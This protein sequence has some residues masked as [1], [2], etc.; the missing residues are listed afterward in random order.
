MLVNVTNQRLI[1]MDI[2]YSIGEKVDSFAYDFVNRKCVSIDLNVYSHCDFASFL[3][4]LTCHDCVIVESIYSF[5]MLMLELLK[6]LKNVE[7]YNIRILSADG[8]IDTFGNKSTRDMLDSYSFACELDSS[9][10]SSKIKK[11]LT[12]SKQNGKVLDRR[13]GWRKKH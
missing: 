4:K 9:Y 8:R 3:N 5:Q 10:R 13:V 11:A 6:T 7:S 1:D 12:I 2:L